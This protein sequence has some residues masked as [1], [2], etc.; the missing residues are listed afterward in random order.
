MIPAPV[1]PVLASKSDFLLPFPKRNTV[2]A[3]TTLARF[4]VLHWM[5][6]NLITG[7]IS[8]TA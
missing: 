2:L 6:S 7:W 4:P 8:H 5:I 1:I 3:C